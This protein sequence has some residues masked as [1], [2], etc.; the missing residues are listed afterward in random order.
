MGGGRKGKKASPLFPPLIQTTTKIHAPAAAV[1]VQ[2]VQIKGA[3]A[4][5]RGRRGDGPSLRRV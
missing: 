3:A 1:H 4:G 5:A 2:T